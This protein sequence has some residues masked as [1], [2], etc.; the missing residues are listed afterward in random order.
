V[1]R[2]YRVIINDWPIA[3]GVGDAVECAACLIT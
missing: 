3:V 2:L 1:D